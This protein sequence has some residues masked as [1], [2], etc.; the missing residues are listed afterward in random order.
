MA[1]ASQQVKEWG[2]HAVPQQRDVGAALA[3]LSE[4][5]FWRASC[6]ASAT[7]NG[8][9][10]ADSTI[11]PPRTIV[12]GLTTRNGPARQPRH[13]PLFNGCSRATRQP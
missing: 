1:G 6:A 8:A 2:R 4:E 10:T 9:A 13:S 5:A 12:A 7:S 11:S 3:A